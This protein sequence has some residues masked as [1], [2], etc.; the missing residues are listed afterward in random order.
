MTTK[1]QIFKDNYDEVMKMIERKQPLR[2]IA[3]FL[4]VKVDTL[5]RWLKQFNIHY[6]GNQNRTGQPHYEQRIPVSEYLGT[7]KPIESKQLKKK[8]IEEGLKEE[9]CECC[10]LDTWYGYK[11]PL[12]LHHKDG[13]HFNNTFDNLQ[14]LCF[15]CHA[16]KHK[17]SQN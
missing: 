1:I 13:N 6:K 16:L 11:I 10:G 14:I 5:K 9:K 4:N 17:Y 15:N 8:L 7:G 2:T 3:Q 12:A